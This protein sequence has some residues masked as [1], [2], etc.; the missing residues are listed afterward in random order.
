M[1]QYASG[2]RIVVGMKTNE[3]VRKVKLDLARKGYTGIRV[4]EV[5]RYTPSPMSTISITVKVAQHR[6]ATQISI[7]PDGSWRTTSI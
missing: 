5:E 1:L 3:A 6:D 4:L 2:L 7:Y